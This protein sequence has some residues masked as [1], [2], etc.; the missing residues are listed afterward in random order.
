MI[1]IIYHISAP[2][3]LFF[4]PTHLPYHQ[5]LHHYRVEYVQILNLKNLENLL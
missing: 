3:F 1:E 4:L 2:T 5:I